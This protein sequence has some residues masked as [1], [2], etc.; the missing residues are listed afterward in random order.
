MEVYVFKTNV[1]YKKNINELARHLDTIADIK[2]WNID[3]H[4]KEKI[5]RIEALDLSPRAVEQTLQNAGFFC[6]ELVD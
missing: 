5:L 3:L 1:R 2:K 4:D 6:K